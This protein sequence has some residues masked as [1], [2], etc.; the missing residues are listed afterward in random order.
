MLAAP[1]ST[2]E[3]VPPFANTAMDGYALRA[4]D[5]AGASD[6]APVHLSVVDEL[7]AG[8]APEIPVGAGEAIRIMT[9][10]PM[11]EGADAVVMV[12]QTRAATPEGVD[13]CAAARPGQHVRAAG[14]DLEAGQIVFEAGTP[15]TAAAI[16]VLSSVGAATV[17]AHPA[18]GSA[19]SRRVTSSSSRARSLPARSA[20][21]TARCCS[22]S[23]RRPASSPSTSGSRSTTRTASS[24]S[25]R[26][27]SRAAMRC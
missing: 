8:R 23:S 12:E 17:R 7:A 25:S 22:A 21:R 4:A 24:R 10:A 27:R 6:D 26:T 3:P 1:V 5:T 14:G 16:G 19:C 9:G 15:L 11:P 2:A 18:R 20:T 13:I